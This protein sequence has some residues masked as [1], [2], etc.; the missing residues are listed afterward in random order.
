MKVR[1]DKWKQYN[2]LS[3]HPLLS[4]YTPETRLYSV[5]NLTEL[6]EKYEFAYIKNFRGGQG[7][8]LFKVEK[9]DEL[10]QSPPGT[11]PHLGGFFY[12]GR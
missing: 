3:K 2:I 8:G 7:M 4:A 12:D 11:C 5:K 10:R 6:L 9:R 1:L